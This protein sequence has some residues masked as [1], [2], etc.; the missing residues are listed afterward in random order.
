MNDLVDRKLWYALQLRSRFEKVVAAQL[1]DKGYEQFLPLYRSR[2]RWSDRLKELEL[3]LFPGYIFCK[4][5]ITKRL[6]ILVIPGVVS[7][8]GLGKMPLAVPEHE[9]SAVQTIVQ[10][11]M[12]YGPW[13][14]LCAGQ[15]VCV[16]YGPLRGLEGVVLEIRNIYQLIISVTLL[17]RSVSVRI[18][19]DS[20][21]PIGSGKKIAA[22]RL[23]TSGR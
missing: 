17:S 8:V 1:Q 5:D 23:P 7:V 19:R 14:T 11:G 12:A 15:P 4:F 2:R 21:V 3:P 9:I 18:D 10:S 6:P 13:P 22:A 20:I 16:R